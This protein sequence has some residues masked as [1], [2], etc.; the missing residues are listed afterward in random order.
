MELPGSPGGGNFLE[1]LLGDLLQLMG[2][3]L[4]GG[5]RRELARTL[6]Q[7]VASGGQAEP[8]V[9]PVERI[10]YGELARVA[11]LHVQELTG[12]SV[13]PSGAPLEV[14][15]VEAGAWAGRTVDD[16]RFL[17]DAMSE[18][19]DGTD[20]PHDPAGPAPEVSSPPARP[21]GFSP[22]SNSPL[23]GLGSPGLGDGDEEDTAGNALFARWMATMGPMMAAMQLG[24]AVGHLARTTLGQYELPVPRSA[25]RLLI[26]PRN[27]DAFAADWSVPLDEVRM[28]VS[29][30]EATTHAVLSRPHVDEAMR[31]RLSEVV[32]GMSEEAS[33]MAD[34]LQGLDPTDI[35][36]LQNLLGDPE[37]LFG[38]ES[39]PERRAA[40]ER[41]MAVTAA[42]LGY[43]EHVLDVAGSRLLVSR[44]A[45]AEAWRR[46]QVEREPGERAA[47]VLLGLDLG[48]AQVERG[49]AFV[50][51]VLER[52]GEEG[53]ARLW[54]AP[55]TLPTP[56]EVDAPGLWLARIDIPPDPGGPGGSATH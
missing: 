7:G 8:N 1:Q 12:M 42:L 31:S 36:A 34:R 48:P 15:A 22:P 35:G 26:V 4:S 33:N 37:T 45:L 14:L 53:L 23:G 3:G 56:A 11:E 49:S 13:T 44:A 39:S 55:H 47:E 38:S 54:S 29:L 5:G 41:L 27:I 19:G 10:R 51:G 40:S 25:G 50:Q 46:R 43:V 20:S 2:G 32:R 17:L 18:V 30:R 6:A 24:S 52:A 28:W 21:F 16:W 9:D